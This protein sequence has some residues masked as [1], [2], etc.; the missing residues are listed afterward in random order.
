VKNFFSLSWLTA[1]P[2]G[3]EHPSLTQPNLNQTKTLK[4]MKN[5]NLPL[6]VL[7]ALLSLP[8]FGQPAKTTKPFL[9]N[10]SWKLDKYP[11][12]PVFTPRKKITVLDTDGPGMLTN[13][14]FSAYQPVKGGLHSNALWLKVFYDN[15]DKPAIDMPLMD[16]LGDVDS[17][18][19]P[20]AT[21]YFS[22]VRQSHNFYLKMPFKKH[23]KIE[24][25]NRSDTELAGYGTIQV[26]PLDRQNTN[27][28]DLHELRVDYRA[29][30]ETIPES[31]IELSNV[32]RGGEIVAH[33]LQL[34]TDEK[35]CRNGELLCEA[36]DEFYLDG[37]ETPSL[38]YLGTE[39]LYGYSWGFQGLQSD[40]KSA[41]FR[42]VNKKEGG[43]IIGMLRCREGDKIPFDKSCKLL[44]NYRH[45][46]FSRFAKN[47]SA[48][49]KSQKSSFEVN[50]KSCVYY[51]AK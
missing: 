46:Y 45:E 47:P 34:D 29:G 9:V 22:K 24:I 26:Q 39:D 6:V 19:A 18:A 21:A 11:D 43:A 38:E 51:Y 15:E 25:E 1:R 28:N 35:R 12:T 7:L 27:I 8:A 44:L 40:G 3:A 16:F 23:V 33:W 20:Y 14:H 17:Q 41:I 2:K 4:K 5:K 42:R 37:E 48:M 49:H 36:N 30:R 31:I 10:I 13:L 32:K 50:Y